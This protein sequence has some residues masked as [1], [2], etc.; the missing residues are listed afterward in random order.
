MQRMLTEEHTNNKKENIKMEKYVTSEMEIT[1]FEAEDV[2]TTS[3]GSY[4]TQTP[5]V[6]EE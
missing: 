2:I 6:W 1:E 5:I 4:P 3:N